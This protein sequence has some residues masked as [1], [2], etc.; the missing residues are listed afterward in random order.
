MAG[1]QRMHVIF[2]QLAWFCNFYN[3]IS[4]PLVVVPPT[5]TDLLAIHG[6]TNHTLCV[7]W[8]AK[9]S[10]SKSA[11]NCLIL[12][13][14]SN[15]GEICYGE[16]RSRLPVALGTDN[17]KV[18]EIMKRRGIAR[19]TDRMDACSKKARLMVAEHERRCHVNSSTQGNYLVKCQVCLWFLSWCTFPTNYEQISFKKHRADLTFFD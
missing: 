10:E 11:I 5:W 7:L 2:L 12:F 3:E 4:K 18:P 1:S 14:N 13:L 15:T 6:L 9:S 8:I 19:E 17:G 16:P